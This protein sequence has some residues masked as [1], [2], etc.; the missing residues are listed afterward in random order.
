MAILVRPM[1]VSRGASATA[2]HLYA[3]EV[4][5]EGFGISGAARREHSAGTCGQHKCERDQDYLRHVVPS[6]S[7]AATNTFPPARPPGERDLTCYVSWC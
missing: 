2:Q 6:T 5:R 1:L 7:P 3:F 4:K